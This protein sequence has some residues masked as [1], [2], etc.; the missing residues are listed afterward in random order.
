MRVQQ[1]NNQAVLRGTVAQ[2]PVFSHEVHGISFYRFLLSVA[3]LSGKEDT[4]KVLAS[5]PVLE[6]CPLSV[7]HEIE[8]LGEIRSFNNRSGVGNRLLITLFARKISLTEEES[9]N[10]VKLHGVICKQPVQRRTPLGRDICDILLA[11]NRSYRRADYLPC[12]AWGSLATF[13]SQLQVGDTI[14]LNGRLQSRQYVKNTEE[15]S[16]EHTA[17]EISI[18]SL[19]AP[20]ET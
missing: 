19:E 17:F 10:Q 13:C 4:V 9:C 16:H 15:G 14:A 7:G 5:A 18:M 12:I 20:G 8:V 1:T 2:T 11:V 6:A 3:R